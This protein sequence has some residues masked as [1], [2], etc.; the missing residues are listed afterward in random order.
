[1]RISATALAWK[2]QT[3]VRMDRSIGGFVVH[4]TTLASLAL[5]DPP[6][7]EIIADL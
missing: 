3:I 6:E 5:E 2:H 1:L 7:K 4:D